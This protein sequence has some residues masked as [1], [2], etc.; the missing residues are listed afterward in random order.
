M[1]DLSLTNEWQH[2]DPEMGLVFPWYVKSVLDELK[3][4]DLKDKKVFE[5][6]LGASTL[7]FVAKGAWVYG[8]DTNK[9]YL[10]AVGEAILAR[11]WKG[12][13]YYIEEKEV[14]VNHIYDRGCLFD[15]VIIDGVWRDD[16]VKPTLDCLKPGGILIFDNWMQPSVEMQSE[17]TQRILTALEHKIYKQEGHLD[18]QTAIFYKP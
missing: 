12:M 8:C 7:W 15:V 10:D 6:G 17:E 1:I 14:Y 5:Y 9:E 11:K 3:T 16:C 13:F 18:W 2:K 4:W